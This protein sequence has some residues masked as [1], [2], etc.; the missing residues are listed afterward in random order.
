MSAIQD[1]SHEL[2]DPQLREDNDDL[3]IEHET[4]SLVSNVHTS[5]TASEVSVAL[6]EDPSEALPEQA[7]EM[8]SSTTLSHQI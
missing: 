5:D 1:L 3:L 4:I 2:L 8:S 6:S 7:H